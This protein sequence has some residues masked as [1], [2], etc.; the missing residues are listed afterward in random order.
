[1]RIGELAPPTIYHVIEEG[2]P[3]YTK[4]LKSQKG[5]LVASLEPRLTFEREPGFEASKSF[6][7]S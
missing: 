2:V 7:I 6:E 1:M 5:K 3:Y 4:P